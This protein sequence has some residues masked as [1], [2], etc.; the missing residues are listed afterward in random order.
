MDPGQAKNYLSS[1]CF[2]D[3]SQIKF[4][5]TKYDAEFDNIYVLIE[6]CRKSEENPDK[7]CRPIKE[8]ELFMK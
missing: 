7:S 3:K 4:K 2:Q 5:N 6:A 1:L 8:I